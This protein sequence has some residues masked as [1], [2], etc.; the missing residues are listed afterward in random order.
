MPSPIDNVPCSTGAGQWF[1]TTHWSVVLAAGDQYSAQ[2]A[3]ALEKLCSAYW[4]PLYTYVR[5]NGHSAEDAQD[6]TQAFF[7]NFLLKNAVS[8]ARRD[9]GRFR[10]F[11]LTSLQNFLAH[12]WE[13]ARAAKRGGGIRPLAWD[14]LSAESQYQSE[15]A[16]DLAPDKA[17][18]R[19]WALTLFQQALTRLHAEYQA[20]GKSDLF[21][22]LKGF[23]SETA[24]AGGYADVAARLN[25]T[26]ATVAVAVHRLRRRY[27]ELVREE[28][29]HTV[30]SP[31]EVQD[32]LRYLIGLV[33]Q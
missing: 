4:Q 27:A 26:A 5:R 2:A 17:F 13:K 30:A 19:R 32:E 16:P 8:R 12:E 33:G 24:D 21:E 7:A 31:A 22:E 14:E 10:S 6:L 3:G 25:M 28:I 23:L 15:I 1:A 20:A 29:A 18:E 9:R 11:L